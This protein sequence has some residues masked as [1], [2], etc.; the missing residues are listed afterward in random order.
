VV[1]A[2]PH[3]VREEAVDK[4]ESTAGALEGITAEPHRLGVEI[5]E[6]GFHVVVRSSGAGPDAVE[7]GA[8]GPRSVIGSPTVC[9]SLLIA[10]YE[11]VLQVGKLHLRERHARK[12]T[13]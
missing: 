5:I 6:E 9:T 13:Q 8:E 3:E 7:E 1:G 2:V 4:A 12:K 11:S 10:S